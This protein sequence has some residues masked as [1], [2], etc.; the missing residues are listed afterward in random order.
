MSPSRE[1]YIK[2]I[3]KLIED[4]GSASNKQISRFLNISKPS[5]SEMIKKLTREGYVYVEG[6]AIRLTQWGLDEARKLLSKHRLWERF[7]KEE[8]EYEGEDIHQQAD[9]LEHVTSEKLLQAL[10]RYLDYPKNCPHGSVIY[11]NVIKTNSPEDA[12]EDF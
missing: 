2:V 10:N 12:A 5:V 6:S 11:E 7:L 8:L 1:D 4:H 3:F 9:L